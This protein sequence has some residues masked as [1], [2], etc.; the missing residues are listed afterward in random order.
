MRRDCCWEFLV[1]KMD[2]GTI[3]ISCVVRGFIFGFRQILNI[4]KLICPH[5]LYLIFTTIKRY[6]ELFIAEIDNKLVLARKNGALEEYKIIKYDDFCTIF[7]YFNFPHYKEDP[8]RK[9]YITSV[10]LNKI[11]EQIIKGLHDKKILNYF[12]TKAER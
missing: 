9:D 8:H 5:G 1:K 2:I 10:D 11:K 4:F 6:R 12:K 3:A 7:S